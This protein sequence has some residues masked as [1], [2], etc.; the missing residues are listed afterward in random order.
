MI[1]KVFHVDFFPIDEIGVKL[2]GRA[3]G[4]GV[5]RIEAWLVEGVDRPFAVYAVDDEDRRKTLE[6]LFAV[7][8]QLGDRTAL[9]TELSQVLGRLQIGK[10]LG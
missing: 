8:R 4:P 10:V 9:Q 6:D 5:F 3:I 7:V 2:E 1:A